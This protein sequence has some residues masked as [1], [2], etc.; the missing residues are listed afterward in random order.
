MESH[1]WVWIME[2]LNSG[3]EWYAD[4]MVHHCDFYNKFGNP[5]LKF[6]EMIKSCKAWKNVELADFNRLMWI[7][8]PE[9][10]R[11]ISIA[12][13]IDAI[14]SRRIYSKRA[15]HPISDIIDFITVELLDSS[16]LIWEN[17]KIKINMDIWRE[18][19]DTVEKN[20]PYCIKY[21]WRYYI[22]LP[23]SRIQF[24]PLILIKN[25]ENWDL[26]NEIK[27]VILENDKEIVK[28]KVVEFIENIQ[29]L[30]D[31]KENYKK[32]IA[33]WT[34]SIDMSLVFTNDDESELRRLRWIYDDLIHIKEE[35][36]VE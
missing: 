25:Y 15:W 21:Q 17:W 16:W 20:L 12:D 34:E 10:W 26:S 14:W 18:I 2:V 19:D 11:M 32:L 9:A 8:I 3:Y 24:D 29:R 23:N 31:K 33:D 22:P 27:L 5:D 6:D 13:T 4:W 36:W 35:Y 1:T 30:E 28:D 7:H